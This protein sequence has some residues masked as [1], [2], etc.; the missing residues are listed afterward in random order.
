MSESSSLY[1]R[2]GRREGIARISHTIIQNHLA[3][4]LVSQR[5]AVVEDMERVERRVIEFFCEGSGGPEHYT[6]QDMRHTHRGMN[7]SEQEFVA[8]I[9]DAM[10]ALE[11]CGVDAPTRTEVL[12]IL[13]S[14]KNEVVRG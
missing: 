10:A 8:V 1:E 12:G 5:Y 2:L 6:G 9:D 11:S 14:M 3:N 7:V 4:P 13:W